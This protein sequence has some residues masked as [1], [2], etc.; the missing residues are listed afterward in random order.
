MHAGLLA[1]FACVPARTCANVPTGKYTVP[2]LW[3]EKEG[4]IV[5]N[6]SSE[7]LRMLNSKF[8]EL[9][10]APQLDLYP[11]DLRQQIDEVNEWVYKSINNGVYRCGFATSQE[12]Y[13][14]AFD[15]L[16]GALGRCEDIL[17]RQRYIIGDSFTEADIRLFM[18]LIRFDE[19]YVVY[20]KTNRRFIHEYPNLR[21]YTRDIYQTPGVAASVN[22]QHIKVHY[23]SSHPKLNYYA[24]VPKG[25]EAWWEQPHNR[26]QR[27]PAKS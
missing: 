14:A 27:F 23:F 7:I 6:E 11:Q 26:Q 2:I 19:V 4:C 1:R 25:G 3:D 8:N 15:E 16:F 9:S 18:T 21:E 20:F 13:E 17:G 22:M 5:N 12:A 10:S 24:V